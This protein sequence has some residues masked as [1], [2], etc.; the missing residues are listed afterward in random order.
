ME[1]HTTTDSTLSILRELRADFPW[2]GAVV[3]AYLR[4]TEADCRDLAVEGS[5]VRLCKGAYEEPESV[6]YQRTDEVDASYVRCLKVLMAGRATRWWPRHDPRAGRHR[7]RAGRPAR[8]GPGRPTSTRCSTASGRTSSAA[9][10]AEGEKMRVYVPYGDQWYGYLMR[11]MAERPANMAFFLRSLRELEGM[12]AMGTRRDRR[13]RGD[14]RDPAVRPAPVRPA[15]GELRRRRA[16]A[17]AG[18]PS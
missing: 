8:P 13:R 2:V 5:R 14:G 11:R 9:W 7:R 17:R 18:R 15:A 12:T 6:A 16:A 3:Q 1:D 4:R 10:P